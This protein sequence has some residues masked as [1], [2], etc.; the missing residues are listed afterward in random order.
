M[1][2][3]WIRSLARYRLNPQECPALRVKMFMC[4]GNCKSHCILA[5]PSVV[6]AGRG[7]SNG[8]S[9]LTFLLIPLRSFAPALEAMDSGGQEEACHDGDHRHG[10]TGENDDEQV[11]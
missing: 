6:G 5:I 2:F 10:D 7:L 11:R 9:L 8:I 1:G 4:K 3:Q